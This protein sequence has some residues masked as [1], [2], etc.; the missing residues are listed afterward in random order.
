MLKA[1]R[2]LAPNSASAELG[3][4]T[5]FALS[6]TVLPAVVEVYDASLAASKHYK[7]VVALTK[8]ACYKN[9]EIT[10][11]AVDFNIQE[12]LTEY[13]AKSVQPHV[14]LELRGSTP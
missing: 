6:R 14:L 11:T 3:L 7:S 9:P 1:A 4:L 8:L 2:I 5:L 10:E 12:P 13:D